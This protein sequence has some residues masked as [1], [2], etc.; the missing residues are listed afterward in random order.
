MN[1]NKGTHV[2]RILSVSLSLLLLVAPVQ[3]DEP[4]DL[5]MIE[6]IRDVCDDSFNGKTIA[7]LGVTFKP[8]TDDMRDAPEPGVGRPPDESSECAV[9]DS[10]EMLAAFSRQDDELADVGEDR[11]PL[12]DGVDDGVLVLHGV[13]VGDVT[14]R[15]QIV[16]V[17]QE[18][19]VGNLRGGGLEEDNGKEVVR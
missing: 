15:Q 6:K 1:K 5:E 7:V 9:F 14:R 11:P 4:V 2:V 3:A 12:G 16:E 17:H 19:L 8:E 18:P 13:E 10:D